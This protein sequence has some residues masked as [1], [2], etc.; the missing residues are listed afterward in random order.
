MNGDKYASVIQENIPKCEHTVNDV[1]TMKA[2]LANGINVFYTDNV[3]ND[4]MRE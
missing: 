1:E 4:W 3:D 2:D